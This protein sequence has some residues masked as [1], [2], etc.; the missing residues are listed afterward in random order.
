MT[1]LSTLWSPASQAY[2]CWREHQQ[3]FWVLASKLHKVV[4]VQMCSNGVSVEQQLAQPQCKQRQ[5][6]SD[7]EEGILDFCNHS[8]FSCIVTLAF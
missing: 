8:H 1:A 3:N 4:P 2:P 5:S 7:T 6:A